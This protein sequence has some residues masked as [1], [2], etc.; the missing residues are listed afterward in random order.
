MQSERPSERPQ[1]EPKPQSRSRPDLRSLLRLA[2]S[3]RRG[4]PSS[5]SLL[6]VALSAMVATP[7]TVAFGAPYE[8]VAVYAKVSSPATRTPSLVSR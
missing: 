8:T 6:R 3:T 4:R 2:T 5:R 1:I 7:A